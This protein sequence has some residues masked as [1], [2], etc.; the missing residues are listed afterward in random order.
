MEQRDTKAHAGTGM[1]VC[2]LAN[3]NRQ[4]RLRF[5]PFKLA[6]RNTIRVQV[7]MSMTRKLLRFLLTLLPRLTQ[8]P[9][10]ERLH[11]VTLVR[12][13]DT[14]RETSVLTGASLISRER[15]KRMG[16]AAAAEEEDATR[17]RGESLERG[18]RSER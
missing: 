11:S 10:I 7:I 5:S 2:C 3:S 16:E 1:P 13:T 14:H 15:E 17:T 9:A 12:H 6:S 18:R 8:H 4:L